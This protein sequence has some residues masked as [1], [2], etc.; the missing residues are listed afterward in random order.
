MGGL[1]TPGGG[2]FQKFSS[3]NEYLVK[4]Q[5]IEQIL[6]LTA[7]FFQN[8][9]ENIKIKFQYVRKFSQSRT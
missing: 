2:D 5:K 8:L 1:G 7:F 9:F 6:G 3:K 4:F